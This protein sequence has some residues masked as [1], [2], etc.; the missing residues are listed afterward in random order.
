MELDRR[1]L[2]KGAGGLAALLGGGVVVALV[3]RPSEYQT[4]A[5]KIAEHILKNYPESRVDRT[6]PII[7]HP[8]YVSFGEDNHYFVGVFEHKDGSRP[9]VLSITKLTEEPSLKFIHKTFFATQ[10][11]GLDGVVDAGFIKGPGEGRESIKR[12]DK[13]HGRNSELG[14]ELQRNYEQSLTLLFDNLSNLNM[15]YNLYKKAA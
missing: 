12:Y 13:K 4:K 11:S 9:P 1:T 6:G 8:T 3:T 15:R 5:N 2:L 10:D 14:K 7:S